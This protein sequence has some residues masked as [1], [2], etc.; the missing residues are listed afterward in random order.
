MIPR[1]TVP[2]RRLLDRLQPTGQ[3]RWH[4]YSVANMQRGRALISASALW[5]RGYICTDEYGSPDAIERRDYGL[6]NLTAQG[7]QLLAEIRKAG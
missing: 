2:Q 7:E 1:L 5:R 3:G 6:V 4:R